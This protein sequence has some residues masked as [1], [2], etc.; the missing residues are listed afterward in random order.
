[1]KKVFLV[2]LFIFFIISFA[3]A[4]EEN[5]TINYAKN[6]ASIDIKTLKY[7]PFPVEP[8]EKFQIW[9]LVK[10]VGSEV[11]ENVTCKIASKFPFSAY[12]ESEKSIGKLA[13]GREFLIDFYIKVDENA[14]EGLEDLEL[15][16]TDNP[17]K[18]AW[19]VK[20]IPIRIQQRYAIVNIVDVRTEPNVLG[21]GQEGKILI[22]ISNNAENIINDVVIKLDIDD[23][24]IVPTKG[25]TIKKVKSIIKGQIS[26]VI[27]DILTLPDAEPGIYKIPLIVEYT[28]SSGNKQVFNTFIS[29]KINEKPKFY[30]IVDSLAKNEIKLKFINN[31]NVD[32][33][34]FN[35]KILD[36]KGFKIKGNQEIYIGSLDSDDYAIESFYASLSKSKV[37]IPLEITYSDKL[38][39]QYLDYV[40]ITLD[41]NKV[42]NETKTSYWPFVILILIIG[43]VLYY[44]RKRSKK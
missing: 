25:T 29:V 8:G 7:E 20:K 35:V 24:P 28:D 44:Y 19:I 31:G 5:F 16:C 23:K 12:S 36:G 18:D 1:M 2:I 32:L 41:K 22:S 9:F 3:Y 43:G 38:N 39:N 14:I 10:N 30:V 40:N 34:L 15:H 42:R 27:F 4:Y 21:I 33:R 26:D 17:K 11:A 6:I 37:V 13:G